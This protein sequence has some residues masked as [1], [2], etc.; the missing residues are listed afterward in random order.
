M[1]T[2]SLLRPCCFH[3]L[4]G[5]TVT[6]KPKP[7]VHLKSNWKPAE[8]MGI[9]ARMSNRSSPGP[10]E[11][12]ISIAAYTLPFFNSIQYGRY[13]LAQ[14]PKLALLFDPILPFLAFYR[15][16]PY[17]SFVAFFAL[18]LGIVRNPNLTRYIRFNS[19]QAITLDVLLVIPLLLH[20]IFSPAGPLLVFS[21]NA[22]FIF[23]LISFLYTLTS[24]VL[25]RTPYLPFL[26]D[27]A[28]RQI[29]S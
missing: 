16:I 19:M 17:S 2:L 9:G 5:G 20:R 25:G 18:Y 4:S 22:I 10:T 1:A 15:S 26:A 13:L 29:S 7:F 24:C 14:Y 8:K 27:A 11:R 21:H 23:T 28:S 3:P 6:L 12:L